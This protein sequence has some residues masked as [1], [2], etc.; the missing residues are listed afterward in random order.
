MRRIVILMFQQSAHVTIN[1]RSEAD[2]D[3]DAI[4]KV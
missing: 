2:L 4:K 1:G 3:V